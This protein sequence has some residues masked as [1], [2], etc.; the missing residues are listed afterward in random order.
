MYLRNILSVS[1]VLFAFSVLL[2]FFYATRYCINIVFVV[3]FVS[4]YLF[5][6]LIILLYLIA[7][8][9]IYILHSARPF[10]LFHPPLCNALTGL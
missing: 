1:V 7:C 10:D 6:V 4:L 5:H 3:V 8:H 2:R 9:I